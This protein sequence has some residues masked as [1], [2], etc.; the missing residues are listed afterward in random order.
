MVG[1]LS[2]W[3][4]ASSQ[5][6][7]AQASAKDPISESA[8]AFERLGETDGAASARGDLAVCYWREGAYDEARVLLNEALSRV[9][10]EELKVR[11]TLRLVIIETSSGHYADAFRLLTDADG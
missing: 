4:G 11:I 1:A 8:A 7:G 5:A 10:D 3:L 6:A 2:G 9:R